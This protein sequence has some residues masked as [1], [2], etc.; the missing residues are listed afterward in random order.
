[1]RL[2]GTTALY[3]SG[4][5]I[6]LDPGARPVIAHRG[7][8][9][10]A[11]EDTLESLRQGMALGADGIEFDVR[12]TRDGHAV[13]IHDPTVDR[14]T[15]GTG[16][17]SSH[18]LAELRTLD[19]GY[20]FTRDNGRTHPWRGQG[21]TV[22]TLDEVIEEFAGTPMIIEIKTATASAETR[23]LIERH[24][25]EKHCLVGSFD[26]RAIVPFIG[27]GI[28]HSAAR[29]DVIR[30]YL[31]ALVPGGPRQLPYEAL[32]IPPI[33]NGLPLP[34]L[35]FA[36]MGRSVGVRTHIWTV[37]DP[38][39]A[40]RLWDGGVNGIISNDPGRILAAAGRTTPAA[41]PN[42]ARQRNG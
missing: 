34:V 31:R 32:C 42:P 12:L 29:G 22:S 11:P 5:S 1:M 18:T 21:I 15:N 26:N 28:A 6:L 2:P 40:L 39:E 27:S 7:N 17:V 20:R 36:R 38:A 23:R 14:T 41:P 16:D 33:F 24:G 4:V 25:I 35:R 8:S 19:F 37:D 9:A 13:V 30:L 10:H 3:L